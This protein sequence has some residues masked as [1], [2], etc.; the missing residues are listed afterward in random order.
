MQSAFSF[1]CKKTEVFLKVRNNKE[2]LREGIVKIGKELIMIP[3]GQ[4]RAVKCN[5]RTSPLPEEQDVLFE[6]SC[7]KYLPEGLEIQECGAAATRDTIQC[8]PAH[9]KLYSS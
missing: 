2:E 6:P 9:H 5:V 1:D 8:Y 4:T 3:A 7:P